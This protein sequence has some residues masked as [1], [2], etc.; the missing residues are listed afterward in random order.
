MG[1]V[2][3]GSVADPILRRRARNVSDQVVRGGMPLRAQVL[4]LIKHCIAT[5]LVTDFSVQRTIPPHDDCK[6]PHH[7]RP[8]ETAAARS[9]YISRWP[10]TQVKDASQLRVIVRVWRCPKNGLGQ[11]LVEAFA[12]Q[13]QGRVVFQKVKIGSRIVLYF[14]VALLEVGG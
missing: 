8:V 3:R 13:V 9:G 2:R 7:L 10:A 11:T 14:P 1:D 12:P 5:I 4:A 6:Q